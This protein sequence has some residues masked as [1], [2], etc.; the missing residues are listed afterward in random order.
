MEVVAKPRM[1]NVARPPRSCRKGEGALATAGCDVARPPRPWRKGEG[2]LA[3]AGFA[4]G[5]MSKLF[6]T[7]MCASA[8]A[9]VVVG[10]ELADEFPLPVGRC[11]VCSFLLQ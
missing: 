11:A 9:M 6:F 8:A 1:H 10:A 3:T 7:L 4:T 2:A 5:Y